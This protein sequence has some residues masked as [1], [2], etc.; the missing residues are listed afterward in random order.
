[1]LF[2]VRTFLPL[3]AALVFSRDAF[4]QQS[5]D[6]FADRIPVEPGVPFDASFTGATFE[7]FDPLP[8]YIYRPDRTHG[9]IWWAW[10]PPTTGF[11]SIV[12]T[13]N[14]YPSTGVFPAVVVYQGDD[15]MTLH[16]PV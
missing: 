8:V 2:S 14:N 13:L 11:A 3:L 4:A 6:N 1:M 10:T 16:D 9:S 7:P 15:L 5:N 12:D